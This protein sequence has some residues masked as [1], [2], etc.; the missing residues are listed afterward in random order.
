MKK[1]RKCERCGCTQ[2]R[3]CAGG[4]AWVG[5]SNVCTACL[6]DNERI[7]YNSFIAD[8]R[9]AETDRLRAIDRIESARARLE[10]FSNTISKPK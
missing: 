8:G 7:F 6:T 10:F 3:A 1:Q 4:C 5:S 9:I 2:R